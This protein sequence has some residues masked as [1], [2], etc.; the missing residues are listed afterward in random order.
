MGVVQ[1][2]CDNDNDNGFDVYLIVCWRWSNP[3]GFWQ[4]FIKGDSFNEV[5]FNLGK[6]AFWNKLPYTFNT[7]L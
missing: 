4:V 2:V 5:I 3:D 6:I 1:E 7:K